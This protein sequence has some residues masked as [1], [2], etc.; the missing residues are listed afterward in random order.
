MHLAT[1]RFSS[2]EPLGRISP[3]TLELVLLVLHYLDN[4]CL[5]AAGQGWS[6]CCRSPYLAQRSEH[7]LRRLYVIELKVDHDVVRIVDRSEY[8]VAAHARSL[9]TGRI[10]IKCLLPGV[11]VANWVFNV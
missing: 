5:W 6:C 8:L 10:A 2:I 4:T 3:G 7:A 9:P 1:L 11:E